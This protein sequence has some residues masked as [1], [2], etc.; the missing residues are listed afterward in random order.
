M[1]IGRKRALER[2]N[3]LAEVVEE[4]LQKIE[5]QPK[6]DSVPHYRSEVRAWLGTMN[7]MIRHVGKKTGETWTARLAEYDRRIEEETNE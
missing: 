3:S 1:G 7:S 6:S 2:L 5:S 4:H